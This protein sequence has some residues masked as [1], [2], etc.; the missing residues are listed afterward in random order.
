MCNE[1]HQPWVLN[2]V[3]LVRFELT[4][5]RFLADSLCQVG[6]GEHNQS[7]QSDLAN[8]KMELWKIAVPV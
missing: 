7:R 4:L 8:Q 3:L 6:V 5:Y 2:M 1:P